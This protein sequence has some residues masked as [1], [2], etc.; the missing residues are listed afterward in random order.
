MNVNYRY[1]ADEILYVVDNA[2]A[3]AVVCGPDFAKTVARRRSKQVQKPWRPPVL[4]TGSRLR[5]RARAPRL[6][7]PEWEPAHVPTGDD[8]IFLYTGGTTGMPKG[9]MWRNDDLY[10]GAV[11]DGAGPGTEPPRPDRGGAGGQ[12]RRRPAC[13]RAR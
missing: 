8:L 6:R 5:G 4:E 1:V 9:V 3:K 2:D 13:R 10:A 12:A 7:R 11:G